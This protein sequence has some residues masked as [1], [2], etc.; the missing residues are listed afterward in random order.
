MS[1]PA[2]RMAPL[3][4]V[5]PILPGDKFAI[6]RAQE[7][8][9]AHEHF[10]VIQSRDEKT[11]RRD[12]ITQ[13]ITRCVRE[14]SSM[15]GK[16]I[17]D[18]D[19]VENTIIT[20]RPGDILHILTYQLKYTATPEHILRAL[21]RA[22]LIYG[23]DT[24]DIDVSNSKN[25]P[26]IDI[27]LQASSAI[28]LEYVT[29]IPTTTNDIASIIIFCNDA[30]IANAVSGARG[31]ESINYGEVLRIVAARSIIV[32]KIVFALELCI[33]NNVP[34]AASYLAKGLMQNALV[35]DM[36]L[37]L[38]DAIQPRLWFATIHEI[39][40]AYCISTESEYRGYYHDTTKACIYARN[41]ILNKL[42]ASSESA[43]EYMMSIT[44][45]ALESITHVMTLTVRKHISTN[46][47]IVSH[48]I[49]VI[50][51]A[52]HSVVSADT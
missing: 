35:C 13:D 5:F 9:P 14:L 51:R 23:L 32:T 50:Y 52:I 37:L 12:S 29:I 44:L 47:L 42:T 41:M 17:A 7:V 30:T 8:E 15:F 34:D 48:P 21:S 18:N 24:R 22:T 27:I 43:S 2:Q 10:A 11:V 26:I 20:S 19:D 40:R 31:N 6:W 46:K 28:Y 1:V 49:N 4:Y 38:Y 25:E 45:G 16:T 36:S 33:R 39:L 3:P